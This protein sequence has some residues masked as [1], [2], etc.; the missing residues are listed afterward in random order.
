MRTRTYI[1]KINTIVS[2]DTINTGINPVAELVYGANVSRMLVYF[3]H[4]K[5]REMV[6]DKVYPDINKLRHYLKI[7]NAGSLDFT[8]LH[9]KD[10]SSISSN[11]KLRAS[12]FD[13]IFFL[14]PDSWDGGKGFDY[15]QTFFN[16]GY[17]GKECSYLNQDSAKLLSYDGSNWYQARNGYDWPE[18]GVY[19]NETLSKEYDKFSSQSGSSIVIA[20]QHFDIGNENINIDITS[21][22]NKF[23]TGELK[24]YG[25]GIAYSPLL[26]ETRGGIENYTGFLTHKTNTFFEPYVETVYDE[27][28]S[29]D[30]SNFILDKENRLYLYVNIG[31]KFENLD[32]MPTCNVN[33]TPYDVHQFS[34]G[35]YYIA[36]T[37]S[38]SDFKANTMFYDVWGN[39]K[40][41]GSILD[42]VEL[43]FVTKLPSLY[44]N[45]GANIEN[46]EKLIPSIYGIRQ[47]E[48]IFRGDVRKLVVLSRVQY[49]KNMSELVN[50]IYYRLYI[51]DGEREI[52]VIPFELVN[53]SFSE[54]FFM[55]D[56]SMLIPEKYYI[57]IKY[58]YNQEV[59]MH[60]NTLSFKI[61]ENL[62]NKY[63]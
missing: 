18:E 5:L 25:I 3:D 63:N 49:Q 50:D 29:D 19:S 59:I 62:N 48:K 17:Y 55:I 26:E 52:D 9:C 53:K 20:R 32:E 35:I 54:N 1:E 47:D 58:V 60:H 28:I 33:G 11:V 7:T 37:I 34:K 38:S 13:L 41:H 22:V 31:G 12:S 46:N 30:R 24:N 8:Q 57:D 6:N 39:I 23:I 42:D 36:L 40:Y 27:C 14:L 2:G 10:V 56:T 51:K 45:V 4:T 44:F 43:D 61:T 16:Q 21:I 15:T